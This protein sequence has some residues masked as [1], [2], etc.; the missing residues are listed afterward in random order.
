MLASAGSLLSEQTTLEAG[1]R[2]DA[3][4]EGRGLMALG[5]RG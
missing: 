5:G 4:A 2:K 3:L 1:N